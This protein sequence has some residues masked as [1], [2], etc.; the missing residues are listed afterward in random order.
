[1]LTFKEYLIEYLTDTQ[2]KKFERVQMTKKARSDTDHYFG[3][4]NDH[5]RE[6]IPDYQ[7]D[8]SETHK[9]L[10]TI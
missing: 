9:K 4:D 2:R 8:K 5:V 10:K 6:E 1:M 7:H 3:K